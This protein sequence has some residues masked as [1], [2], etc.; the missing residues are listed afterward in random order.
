VDRERTLATAGETP[1][2]PLALAL[3]L[4]VLLVLA[5]LPSRVAADDETPA[6][7]RWAR[8]AVSEDATVAAAA[9]A[10]LRRLG[11]AGLAALLEVHAADLAPPAVDPLAEV[12]LPGMEPARGAERLR[13]AIEAVAAQRDALTSRLYWFTDLEAA[14]AEARRTGRPILSLWLLGRLDEEKSCANSRFF[15]TV[16]YAN[17]EVS[18]ALRERFVLH[19]KSVRP[20]PTVTI[21]FGDGRRIERTITGNSV[22]HVLDAEGRPV[23]VLPGLYGP[24]AFL[25]VL[26]AAEGAARHAAGLDDAAR[27]AHLR[28]YHEERLRALDAAWAEDLRAIGRPDGE[29]PGDGSPWAAIAA[30]HREDAKLDSGSVA[31]MRAKHPPAREAG[32][33]AVAKMAVEDPILRVVHTFEASIAVDTVRNEQRLHRAV[34]GWLARG[35]GDGSV[36]G[37]NERVYAELFLTPSSDPWLGLASEDDYCALEGG[38][39]VK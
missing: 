8:D 13:G 21:D 22:H 16:L 20:V 6:A 28:R 11:P 31:L 29:A 24:H 19:W 33:V 30:L 7:V 10:E 3:L 27:A 14:K 12:V 17:R 34:H 2:K 39:L 25:R 9:V 26:T 32:F 35:E 36:E 15:R 18:E 1:M 4:P 38:G 23:D 5:A 37:L